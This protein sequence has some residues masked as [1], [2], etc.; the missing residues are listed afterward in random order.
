MLRKF[1]LAVA[2]AAFTC[3]SVS[4]CYGKYAM[5]HAVHKWNGSLGNKFVVSLVHFL[6]NYVIPVYGVAGFIDFLILNTIEFWTGSNPMAMG[7]TYEEMDANGNKVYAVKNP[8]GTLS[9]TITDANGKQA[10]FMLVRNENVISVVDAGGTILARQ[11]HDADGTA[12]E[13][14]NAKGEVI[15]QHIMDA[16]GVVA[17]QPVPGIGNVV[18]VQYAAIQP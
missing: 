4:G 15:A 11:T 7:N 12:R 2:L 5:W 18:P 16:N 8:D 13:I 6:F 14:V 9:V 10:D 1:V 17:A 3:V